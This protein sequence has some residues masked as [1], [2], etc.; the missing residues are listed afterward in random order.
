[1]LLKVGN[2]PITVQV[3]DPPHKKK[4]WPITEEEGCSKVDTV[5][6]EMFGKLFFLKIIIYASFLL[7]RTN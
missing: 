2:L 7:R 6:E 4:C 5:I 3:L 1:M